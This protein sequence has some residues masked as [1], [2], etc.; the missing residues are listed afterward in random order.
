MKFEHL[1]EVND[2]EMPLILALTRDQVWAGLMHRVLDARPFMPGLDE[3][4][5]VERFDNG[6]SRR[7]RWGSTELGD[8]VTFVEGEWVAFESHPTELHGGGMLTMR[9]EEPAPMRLFLRFTYETVFALGHET[10][11]EAYGDY[12]RD[13][14]EAADIDTVAVIRQLAHGSLP[15]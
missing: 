9:I 12:L 3:C 6:L 2:P 4:R 11:D 5:I 14:Y 10:E 7:L 15:H 13:A 1:V 8:R